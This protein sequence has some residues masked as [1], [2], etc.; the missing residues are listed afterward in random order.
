M[1]AAFFFSFVNIMMEDDLYRAIETSDF[2][3]GFSRQ[4]LNFVALQKRNS[5]KNGL[6]EAQFLAAS[7]D[8]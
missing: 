7:K 4:F 3:L 6:L 1:T 5:H 8:S 2:V